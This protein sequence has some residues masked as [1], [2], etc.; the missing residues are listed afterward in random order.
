MQTLIIRRLK[1]ISISVVQ[2]L[3]LF[4]KNGIIEILSTTVYSEVKAS[5]SRTN[6]KISTNLVSTLF[7]Q[8]NIRLIWELI[9]GRI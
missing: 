5:D 7:R 2:N 1:N 6:L 9:F 4:S 3:L 8:N